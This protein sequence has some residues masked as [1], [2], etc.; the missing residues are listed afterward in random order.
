M[1]TFIVK[2][3]LVLD[4]C[5]K[6]SKVSSISQISKN[7]DSLLATLVSKTPSQGF[8]TTT[9]SSY[10]KKDNIY[11]LAQCRG[12]ISNTDCSNYIQDAAKKIRENFIGKPDTGDGL[13]Y[14]NVA[15]VTE[16]DPKTFDN[17]LGELFDRI[18]SEAALR[19]SQGLG[20]G[21][22]KLTPFVTLNGLVEFTRD[23]NALGCAQGRRQ[24]ERCGG[25]F[26]SAAQCFAT[27]D[28]RSVTAC[29]NK[30]G[31]RVL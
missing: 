14:Y 31:C 1:K 13:I 26:A 5:N 12:D 19:E 11:G 9:S 16:T 28:L 25:N 27:A 20:K 18:R 6:N 29:H 22:R 23:L 24:V 17:K 21:K 2:C 30:K 3:L 15:N 8:T 10:S 4:L 7:I